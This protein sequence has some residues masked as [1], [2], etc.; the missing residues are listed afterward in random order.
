MKPARRSTQFDRSLGWLRCLL[1]IR[2]RNSALSISSQF[3]LRQLFLESAEE[4]TGF[5]CPETLHVLEAGVP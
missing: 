2:L 3:R 4:R 5:T 1:S